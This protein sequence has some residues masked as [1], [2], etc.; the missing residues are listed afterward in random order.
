M[1]KFADFL[2]TNKI[3][4]Y[5][6]LSISTKL[7]HLR[8]EDRAIRLK[9][10]NTPKDAAAAKPAEG[11]VVA[12]PPKP[13]SGRPITPRALA[14]A[15]AGKAISGPQKTRLLRAVNHILEQ[16]KKPAVDLRQLF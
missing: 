11:E 2:K 16:K 12:A 9:K 10:R 8:P 14:A 6:L 13:R 7:E 1:S 4:T 3:N 15:S 5:R